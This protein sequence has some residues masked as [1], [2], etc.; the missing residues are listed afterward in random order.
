MTLPH[1]VLDGTSVVSESHT[2]PSSGPYTI[3]LGVSAPTGWQ[4]IIPDGAFPVGSPNAPTL[5][6][7]TAGNVSASSVY[8]YLVTFLTQYGESSA[9]AE[10]VV[11]LSSSQHGVKIT[12]IPLG[13][14]PT[15]P[16]LARKIYRTVAGGS[17]GSE[18]L[19]AVLDDNALTDY[20]DS[21]AD[22]DLLSDAIPVADNSGL[23][24]VTIPGY[25]EVKSSPAALHF[26]VDYSSSVTGGIITFNS[27]NAGASI[28]VSYT[29]GT[30]VNDA[31]FNSLIDGVNS[32]STTIAQRVYTTWT[33]TTT[34]TTSL[35]ALPETA[36]TITKKSGTSKL[37][38][39]LSATFTNN[40]GTPLDIVVRLF[41]STH[42]VF[43]ANSTYSFTS[44]TGGNLIANVHYDL[45]I[46]SLA[47]TS[48]N[49]AFYAQVQTS[50]TAI[51]TTNVGNFTIEEWS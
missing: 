40:S 12:N 27:S 34:V 47:A 21:T 26:T 28:T 39:T 1:V 37:R 3:R 16:V 32:A 4:L 7:V 15:N 46:A 13:T 9:G 22:G 14:D 35:A 43:Y 10:A 51:L 29:G 33:P 5:T 2:I 25:T 23:Q 31:L 6:A 18:T 17:T 20:V 41:D 45:E 50:G 11:T 30:L 44:I 8:K 19:L 36:L 42:S 24:L 48:Y 49:F 38:C